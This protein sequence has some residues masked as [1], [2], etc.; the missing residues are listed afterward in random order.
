MSIVKGAYI[1]SYNSLDIGNTQIGFKHSYSYRGRNI[2]FDVVGSNPV[3]ILLDGLDMKVSFVA[4]EFDLEAIDILRWPFS[5]TVGI[6]QP[7]GISMWE[8]AKPLLLTGC[9]ETT[10]P[11]SIL[12]PKTILAPDYT[13]DI[14]YNHLER[15]LPMQLLVFPVQFEQSGDPSYDTPLMPNGCNPV[16]YFI[17][18][19]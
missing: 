6:T 10:S 2:V 4:Q 1:G 16:L 12:F 18:V 15:P 11:S 9:S 13:L 3:D 19:A 8:L 5:G 17:E 7:T 14:D